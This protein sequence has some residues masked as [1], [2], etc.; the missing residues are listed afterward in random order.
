MRPIE[1]PF[2]PSNVFLSTE[3]L[4]LVDMRFSSLISCR[5]LVW[6][7][8]LF[9]EVVFLAQCLREHINTPKKSP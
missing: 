6:N 9:C 7:A 4:S 5:F 2:F 3:I 8:V 1:Y